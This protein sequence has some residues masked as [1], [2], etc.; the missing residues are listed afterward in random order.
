MLARRLQILADGEEIDV[1]R[2]Q[3]VHHLQHLVALLAEADHDAG[4]GEQRRVEL[5]GALQQPQ[6]SEIARARP[7]GQIFR[8]HG[9][10]IVVE[11]VGPAPR[12]RSRARRPCAGSPASAP[13]SSSPARRA[14]MAAI[15]RGEMR[16]PPSARSSRSTEVTTTW[17]R[18]SLAT[19]SATRVRLARIERAGQAGAHIAEGAGARAGVAH[20]H[21]GGVRLLPALADIGAAGLLA[22]RREL[23]LADDAVVSAHSAEPGAFTPDPI[24]LAQD[25]LIGPMRLLRMS[26]PGI[27][28][29]EVENEGHGFPCGPAALA[30]R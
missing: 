2:A 25:R 14:R 13:R 11:D 5:L 6:R 28:V 10:E 30:Q 17:L 23:V 29:Q 26:R 27:A 20:D 12:P 16:A 18:P 19:A 7:H 21:E 9:L 8:R 15:V 22:D 3:I 4:L 1:G 24:G